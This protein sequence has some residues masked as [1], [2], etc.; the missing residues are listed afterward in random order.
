M[1]KF[2]YSKPEITKSDIAKVTGVMKKGYLTQGSE[3][4]AFEYDIQKIF[5]SKYSTI[6][7]SG[8]AALHLVYSALGIGPNK[9]LL[10][11]PITFLA[12]ANAARMCNAQVV[13]CDVDPKTGL[14][15]AELVEKALKKHKNK[16]KVITVVHLGGQLCNMK[17]IAKIA[18]RYN[19][20]VVEDA[21]HAPGAIYDKKYISGSCKYSIA[22]TFSFHA[23]KHIAMGEGGCITTNSKDIYEVVSS[24][25]NHGIVRNKK[26]FINRNEVHS[27]WYYEMQ[28]LG[29]NYRVDEL[30]CALG[31]N[32]LTRLEKNIKRRKLLVKLYYKYLNDIEHLFLPVVT[33]NSSHSWHLFSVKID[34]VKIKKSRSEVMLE[35]E[36]YGIESQVHYIPL[37][38]QP[39]YKEKNIKK[40]KGANEYYQ[41][42]LSI[43][44]YVQLKERDIIY[45]CN[46]LKSILINNN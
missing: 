45:I 15:T 27:K 1:I 4:K 5:K 11:T 31:R 17:A 44:L 2:P 29:W 41:N 8:T 37:Y 12:T 40:Y 9:G 38:L 39:F 13:F 18:K 16:I 32:Q 28:S 7:N 25:R 34:F 23:I 14:M 24:K 35:L 46:A 42:T 19:C 3:I 43:P 33:S 21:C 22:C 20:L 26:L 10:T 36:R 30:T 6:C